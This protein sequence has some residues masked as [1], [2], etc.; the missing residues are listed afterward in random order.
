MLASV[1]RYFLEEQD[2]KEEVALYR[3]PV[4]SQALPAL[5]HASANADGAARSRSGFQFPPFVIMERGIT[6]SAWAAERERG[7]GEV[8]T[9]VDGIAKLLAGIHAAGL[10]H[11]DIKPANTLYLLKSTTWKLLDVG[12][13]ARSGAAFCCPVMALHWPEHVCALAA[14]RQRGDCSTLL[15]VRAVIAST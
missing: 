4:L 6:L 1:R 11:R 2:F 13:L 15:F 7:L 3:D 12:I 9:M 5:L 14:K 10:V 8:A